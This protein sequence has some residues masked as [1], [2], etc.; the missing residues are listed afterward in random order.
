MH[1][2]MQCEYHTIP[3]FV[4]KVFSCFVIKCNQ[5]HTGAQPCL[6][7]DH[8]TCSKQTH[9]KA[10]VCYR[11]DAI[12]A[13]GIAR[14]FTFGGR[15]PRPLHDPAIPPRHELTKSAYMDSSHKPT[16]INH[17]HEKLL[18]LQVLTVFMSHRNVADQALAS[19]EH[20]KC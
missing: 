13:I 4:V 17:F 10:T 14:C 6:R 15:F 3:A 1:V 9:S 2:C 8:S 20:S 16:T 19:S 7:A 11:L 5:R 18:K 12:G